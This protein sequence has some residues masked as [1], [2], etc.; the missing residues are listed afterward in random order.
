MNLA[1]SGANKFLRLREALRSVDNLLRKAFG[2]SRGA[3]VATR[4]GS[5]RFRTQLSKASEKWM[6]HLRPGRSMFSRMRKRTAEKLQN[7]LE[8]VRSAENGL[9]RAAR[10]S[11]DGVVLINCSIGKSRSKLSSAFEQEAA[12]LRRAQSTLR[13]LLNRVIEKPRRLRQELHEREKELRDL[14]ASSLDPIV[15]TNDNRRFV[16]ANQKALELFGVSEKNLGSFTID[17]FFLHGPKLGFDG[18]ASLFMSRQERHAKCKI[19]RLD[20]SLR[21]AECVF[22]ANFVPCRHLCRFYDVT[23]QNCQAH[24]LSKGAS[25]ATAI[26]K[27]APTLSA[28]GQQPL[29]FNV[30]IQV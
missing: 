13:G 1:R 23:P 8:V 14:L 24:A 5:R 12:R 30:T 27:C 28:L 22:V 20:G 29:S 15:V 6:E 4:D 19:R 7:L 26:C 18:R 9:R 11:S 2:N 21:F 3:I 10:N 25:R 16:A 17:V